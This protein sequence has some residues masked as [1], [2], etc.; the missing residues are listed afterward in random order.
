MVGILVI[1]GASPPWI[2]GSVKS[3]TKGFRRRP[4]PAG[5]GVGLI[6][7]LAD[8]DGEGPAAPG[9]AVGLSGDGLPGTAHAP[10]PAT[11]EAPRKPSAVRR[12][13]VEGWSSHM[14]IP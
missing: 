8:D 3:G 5:L 7:A 13:A 14:E 12:L 1:T 4:G 10:S 9:V 11:R 2:G 6:A